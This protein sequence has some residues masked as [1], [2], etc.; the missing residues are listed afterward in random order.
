MPATLCR[1]MSTPENPGPCK[2]VIMTLAQPGPCQLGASSGSWAGSWITKGLTLD[3]PGEK[4]GVSDQVQPTS[5]GWV[6][7]WVLPHGLP[8]NRPACSDPI[9]GLRAKEWR[10]SV[11]DSQTLGLCQ[12]RHPGTT[13]LGTPPDIWPPTPGNASAPPAWFAV[14]HPGFRVRYVP[15]ILNPSTVSALEEDYARHHGCRVP[16]HHGV[17]V[18]VHR[19]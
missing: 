4:S 11:P 7:R 5:S 2:P 13:G 3:G 10:L 17:I 19:R 14:C 6:L 18:P 12:G 16:A 1:Q 15:I 8:G 9:K